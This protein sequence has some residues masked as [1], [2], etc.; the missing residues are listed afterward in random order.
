MSMRAMYPVLSVNSSLFR[1]TGAADLANLFGR[2]DDINSEFACT[3]DRI[4]PPLGSITSN[5]TVDTARLVDDEYL[6]DCDAHSSFWDE[7]YDYPNTTLLSS[8]PKIER[9]HASTRLVVLNPG[10]IPILF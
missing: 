2:E 7:S 8:S 4:L 5:R 3:V 6:L 1:D 9:F 10:L